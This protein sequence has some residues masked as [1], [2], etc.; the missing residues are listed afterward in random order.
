MKSSIAAVLLLLGLAAVVASSFVGNSVSEEDQLS[1]TQ[2]VEY[3]TLLTSVHQPT[4]RVDP[5]RDAKLEKLGEMRDAR[6]KV[7]MAE[8]G[9]SAEEYGYHGEVVSSSDHLRIGVSSGSVRVD[10]SIYAGNS[11]I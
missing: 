6:T 10:S 1:E 2:E 7:R 5:D 8:I 11:A 3:S 4:R 9:D